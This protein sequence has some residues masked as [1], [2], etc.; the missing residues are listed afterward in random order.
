MY[1]VGLGFYDSSEQCE[2]LPTST[3]LQLLVWYSYAGASMGINF[4]AIEPQIE[5]LP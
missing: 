2:I 1:F 5:L 4:T 3:R